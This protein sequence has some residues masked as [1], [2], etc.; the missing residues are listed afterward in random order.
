[1]ASSQI[2]NKLK[3][4]NT[5]EQYLEIFQLNCNSISNKLSEIKM[6]LYTRK[7]DIMCLCETMVKNNEP[8]FIGYNSIWKHRNGDKGGLAIL[9]RHDINFIP[10]QFNTHPNNGLEIQIIEIGSPSGNIKIANIYNPHKN[11]YIQELHHYLDVL[12][13]KF[14]FI[15]DFNA[16]SPIWDIDGR[17]NTTGRNIEIVL[18]SHNIGILNDVDTPTYID[19]KT[20]TTSC[21]DLCLA[22]NNLSNIGELKRGPDIG[23][24]HFPIECTFGT[25]IFK[26]NLETCKKWKLKKA[27]WKSWCQDLSATEV[28]AYSENFPLDAATHNQLLTDKIIRISE[29][30]IPKTT[31]TKKYKRLTPWWDE[32][33]KKAVKERKKAKNRLW[34]HPTPTN[35]ISH[36]RCQAIVKHLIKKK[37]KEKWSEFASTMTSNTPSSKVWKTIKSINGIQVSPNLPIGDYSSSNSDKANQL[38]T[39]FTRFS[40]NNASTPKSQPPAIDSQTNYEEISLFEL[41]NCIRRLKNTSPGGDRICN[42]FLKK[43]PTVLLEEILIL[44]NTSLISGSVPIE[45]KKGIICPILKPG[46]DSAQTSSYRP[47]A[48]LSCLGKLMERIIQKRLEF[49]LESNHIF[50]ANQT[51]FRKCRGTTDILATLKNEIT[52]T[53][54]NKEITIVTYLDLQSAY[55]SVWHAGLL[56]KLQTLGIN[57]FLFKWLEDYLSDRSTK[58]RVGASISRSTA[59]NAGL[60]QGA[61]LSPMLFNIMLYDLPQ[62]DQVKILSYADDITISSRA[63]NIQDAHNKMQH[64]LN[65]ITAWL[66]KW[67]FMLNPAKCSFQIFTKKKNLPTVHLQ[68]MNQQIQQT[69]KQRVLGIIFD[70]PKLTLKHH[71]TYLK[72]EC[73][74]RLNIMRALSSNRW[75]ASRNLLRRVYISFIRSKI[76]YGSTIYD[77]FTNTMQQKLNVIQNTALR[78]MLGA[79]KTSPILSLEIEAYIVPLDIRF[80]LLFMKWYYKIMYSPEDHLYPEIGREVGILPIDRR[81]EGFFTDRARS[82]FTRLKLPHIKRSATP[83]ISPIKPSID[84]SKI[85]SLDM[86]DD[87]MITSHTTMNIMFEQF[88]SDKYTDHISIYTDGSKLA[89][90]STSAAIYVPDLQITTTWKLNPTHSVLG[91]ELFA[92]HRALEIADSH[93]RLIHQKIVI[94]TDSKSSLHLISN[95]IDPSYKSSV[96]KIQNLLLKLI[97]RVRLQWV[98]S[99]SGITGNEVADRSANLGHQ[100]NISAYS[101][102]SF[103]ESLRTLKERFHIFWTSVW[104]DRVIFSQKGKFLS[105]I[106]KE[107]KFR[108]WLSQKSR[109]QETALARLRI[110]H[111]GLNSHMHRFEMRDSANCTLCNVPE[112]V[113][114]FLIECNQYSNARNSMKEALQ[115]I[116]VNLSTVNLL[117][118]GPYDESKQ[119][120]I[121]KIVIRFI[122][123]SGKIQDF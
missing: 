2:I 116:N 109:I 37:K 123:D 13:D 83:N 96:Q 36:R 5:S 1:M 10:V 64:C 97:E 35:L 81:R 91:S 8:K 22:S 104:K 58:V 70:S 55:D 103:N 120:K 99:H 32:D 30:H 107:P 6:Y 4:S 34:R 78:I 65:R 33:C 23:S 101:Y 16:H 39:H 9:V 42:S 110:G 73:S 105:N 7:P 45:W 11:I 74:R 60:P 85:I 69:E 57:S 52:K 100:N 119:R 89:D 86:F 59:L 19:N 71:I 66:D 14:I 20:G 24:D 3:R 38:L 31:G 87:K 63:S 56:K 82:L 17:N 47:I 122:M 75:G 21:L 62:S 28:H 102:V 95:T 49:F 44:F 94:I 98:R 84:L 112:T 106:I 43:A 29:L 76:E 117:L 113:D 92:I 46:K 18:D 12:G 79:R 88:I 15:G 68:I 72:D 111:V 51:G 114:H 61:V 25:S 115:L 118:G 48:M 90:D 53:F 80:K 93:P 50:T 27:D 54:D 41:E 108:P 40:S 26:S 121:H 77:D 67:K